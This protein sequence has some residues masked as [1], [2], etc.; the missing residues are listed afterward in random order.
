MQKDKEFIQKM[1]S[2]ML[3]FLA[4]ALAV[5]SA[6]LLPRSKA[7]NFEGTAVVGSDF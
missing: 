6:H 1:K 4:L 2:A 3:I 5:A 7:P